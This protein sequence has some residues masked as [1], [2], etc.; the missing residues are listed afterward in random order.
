MGKMKKRFAIA[1]EGH[2]EWHYF[3][4]LRKDKR[5][6]FKIKPDLPKH[7]DWKKILGMARN[8]VQ[9]GYDKVFCVLDF[10]TI[11]NN[12]SDLNRFSAAQRKLPK[13][14]EIIPSMPCIEFW[15]LLHY[16]KNASTKEYRSFKELE[17]DLLKFIPKYQKSISYFKAC[18]LYQM[19]SKDGK[20]E[21]AIRL[22]EEL[23]KL[24]E[25]S[26]ASSTHP[27]SDIDKL[28][29]QLSQI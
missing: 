15:F 18:S 17:P 1:G 12:P 6:P 8:Y 5:Y 4:G 25:Q 3:D 21:Q 10:D 13:N 11:I 14:I 24:K 16:L 9:Q 7:S 27:F 23:R 2:T 20:E 26:T 19:L 28:L 29:L 22:A